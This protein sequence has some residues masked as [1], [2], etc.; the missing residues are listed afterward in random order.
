M[1]PYPKYH[2]N[3]L[4]L[5]LGL[6]MVIDFKTLAK[7]FCVAA[8][9]VAS[10]CSKEPAAVKSEPTA[11][12]RKKV[13]LI[14]YFSGTL[15]GGFNDMIQRFNQSNKDLEL[16]VSALDHEAFKSSIVDSLSR[17]N[18]PDVY[19]YWAGSRVESIRDKLLPIDSMWEQEKLSD[20]FSPSI[21][22]SAST[23]QGKKY[24]LPITQHYVGFYYNKKVFDAAGLTP[25]KTWQQ[26]V[27]A[28]ETLKKRGVT[29]I[30]LGSKPKWPAQFWFDYLL[31]RTAP[32]AYRDQLLSGKARY[33]DAQVQEVFKLWSGLLVK[34][35]FNANPNESEWDTGAAE[36]VYSGKAGMTLMGTWLSS[37][38]SDEKHKWVA[39]TDY[40]FFSFPVIDEKI[41]L[42]ALGPVDGL[43]VP[44]KSDNPS[45]ALKVLAFMASE[46]NQ[47]LMSKGS[48]AFA[49]NL[50]IQK[51]FY[52]PFQQ[53]I[54]KDIAASPNWAFNYDLATPPAA[55]AIGL[56]AFVEFLKFPLQYPKVL[57]KTD[58]LMRPVLDGK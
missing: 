25:P 47:K 14:H 28:C 22:A 5:L 48:G 6:A 15:S 26:F 9:L 49:P 17:E 18:P 37:F 23:Y 38:F 35:Y 46:E 29:P 13:T 44:A 54:L 42:T 34:G 7:L 36:D 1:P 50:G 32:Y 53:A 10:G 16:S 33:T 43:I 19:S 40:G 24:V 8:V 39:D 57:E 11:V 31:L 21:V 20:K 58:A 2:D 4:I 56:D 55:A 30:A 51:D 41:P 12:A 52:S 27:D 45:G 3:F